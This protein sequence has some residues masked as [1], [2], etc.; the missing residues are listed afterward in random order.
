MVTSDAEW[1]A[2]TV[3]MRGGGSLADACA[4]LPA[5]D[6]R[7]LTARWAGSAFEALGLPVG[8]AVLFVGRT[9]DAGVALAVD[10][11]LAVGVDTPQREVHLPFLDAWL[12]DRAVGTAPW[13]AIVV[14]DDPGWGTDALRERLRAAL[15]EAR[16]DAPVLVVADNRWSPLRAVDRLTGKGAGTSVSRRT[17]LADLRSLDLV[18]EREYG[19]LRSTLSPAAVF[20]LDARRAARAALRGASPRMGGLRRRL[21]DALAASARWRRPVGWLMPGWALVAGRS[22]QITTRRSHGAVVTA[23]VATVD[24]DES[25]LLFGEPPQAME[26]RYETPEKAD[27]EAM[28][29]EVMGDALP[30]V[31]PRLIDRPGPRRV[32]ME[33][34]TGQPVAPLSMSSTAVESWLVEAARLLARIHE[35]TRTPDGTVLVHG[36]YWL[37]NLLTDGA[38]VTG[39]VDWVDA[40]WGSDDDDRLHLVDYLVELGVVTGADAARLHEVVIRAMDEVA[41]G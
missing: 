10:R 39:V 22:D 36:D 18:V 32:R 37:G 2:A 28:A 7:W 30:G 13:D 5:R 8:A 15:G 1:S 29:L 26:K 24:A 23:R 11:R 38:E 35:A 25:K 4:L 3:A 21:T 31:A 19:L 27:A 40:R 41:K 12:P 17:I 34:L 33:W 20:D 16:P 14:G 6:A 9:L